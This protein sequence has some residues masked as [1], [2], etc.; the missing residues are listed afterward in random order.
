MVGNKTDMDAGGPVTPDQS[1]VVDPGEVSGFYVDQAPIAKELDPAAVAVSRS[2]CVITLLAGLQAG[3]FGPLLPSIAQTHG[4]PLERAGIL[5]SSIFVGGLISLVAS[6]HIL[7]RLSDLKT[8]LAA[9]YLTAIGFIGLGSLSGLFPLA[10]SALCYGMGAGLNS[11]ASHILFPRY[12]PDRVAS[13][14]SK[15]NA[16]FGIGALIGPLVVLTLFYGRIH[17]HWIFVGAGFLAMCLTVYLGKALY[18]KAAL[19]VT[20]PAAFVEKAQ[21]EP[22]KAVIGHPILIAL[23]LINFIYVGSETSLGAWTYTFLQR[24]DNLDGALASSAISL[25]WAGLTIG[26]MVSTRVC[27]KVNPKYVTMAAMII[28]VLAVFASATIHAGAAVALPLVL[29]IGFGL[30]PIFPTVIAQSAIRFPRAS[31]TTTTITIAGGN[32]GGTLLPALGGYVLAR[33]GAINFM[34]LLG[35]TCM[36]M[37]ILLGLALFPRA[38]TETA[39]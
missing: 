14:L 30:G 25:L 24:A 12:Y 15:L 21:P 31:S 16:F 32:F 10:A 37:P 1:A 29:L 36:L 18:S 7:A 4:F 28:L 38:V 17:Y 39:K 20:A 3:W 23:V 6:K 11:I 2:A 34:L 19:T 33:Y 5:V 27:L 13:S 9:T 8:I 35:A 26:R 22:I